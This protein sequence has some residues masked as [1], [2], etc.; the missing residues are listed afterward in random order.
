MK[1]NRDLYLSKPYIEQYQS[2]LAGLEK[3]IVTELYNCDQFE[4]DIKR[5]KG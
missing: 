1:K 5:N 3:E 4:A 2:H